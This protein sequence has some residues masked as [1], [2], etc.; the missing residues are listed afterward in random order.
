MGDEAP[1]H[2]RVPVLWPD[3]A[4]RGGE[5]GGRSLSAWLLHASEYKPMTTRYEHPDNYRIEPYEEDP[6]NDKH[7]LGEIKKVDTF[8]VPAVEVLPLPTSQGYWLYRE[9]PWSSGGAPE[10]F[11]P[12][13]LRAVFLDPRGDGF[14]DEHGAPLRESDA[15]WAKV[16]FP[17][18]WSFGEPPA[19]KAPIR[20]LEDQRAH[21]AYLTVEQL[22]L[23]HAEACARVD[24]R[25]AVL[26][27]AR[28]AYDRELGNE[29]AIAL[30]LK[31][32]STRS[33]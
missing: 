18:G 12:V 27:N 25:M 20:E 5:H 3:V 14:M 22:L 21:L 11:G 13:Q 32:A 9:G 23:K 29:V 30:A 1:P 10:R 28:R 8:E 24:V 26:G 4:V 6:M 19:T 15:Q 31:K 7:S 17:E 16:P 2:A 33:E